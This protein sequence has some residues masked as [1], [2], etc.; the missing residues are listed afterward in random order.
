MRYH[1]LLFFLSVFRLDTSMVARELRATMGLEMCLT[2]HV[3]TV[4]LSKPSPFH[5]SHACKAAR[6]MP[7]AISFRCPRCPLR[8]F[9]ELFW[10][11]GLRERFWAWRAVDVSPFVAIG[12]DQGWID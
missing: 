6:S 11:R 12:A 5:V 1:L 7:P 4:K 9:W 10:V 2:V 8:A 3:R